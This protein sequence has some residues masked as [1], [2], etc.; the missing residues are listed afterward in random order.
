MIDKETMM[1]LSDLKQEIIEY[2]ALFKTY[3][4]GSICSKL[5]I[6]PF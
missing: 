2:L 1:T 3:E 6:T 5:C 4:L